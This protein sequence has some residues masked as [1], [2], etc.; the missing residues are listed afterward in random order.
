VLFRSSVYVEFFNLFNNQTADQVDQ[1]YTVDAADPVIGGSERDLPYVKPVWS[2]NISAFGFPSGNRSGGPNGLYA[3]QP[4][5]FQ[6]SQPIVQKLNFGQPA[7]RVD[8][9]GVRL[10]ASLSF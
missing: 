4:G 8:P 9:L 1:Q 3:D 7:L 2:P 10:G 6:A 5:S